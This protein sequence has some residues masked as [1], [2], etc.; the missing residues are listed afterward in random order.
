MRLR[1]I[2]LM[3]VMAVAALPG[4]AG[5]QEDAT[6]Y[7]VH[8]IPGA[9]VN[10]TAGG[11]AIIENFTFQSIEE[12]SLPAGTYPIGVSLTDGTEVYPEAD[13]TVEAGMTYVAVAYLGEDG[14]PASGLLVSEVNTSAIAAG[15]ARLTAFHTAAAPAVDILT[16]D[17]VLFDGVANGQSG[18][19]DVPADTYPVVIA[20]D[21]DN[22]V[23][24]FEGDVE[25]AEGANTLVFA[26][27]SLDDGNFG[28]VI[29]VVSGLGEMPEGVPSGEGPLGA[30]D[31]TLAVAALAAGAVAL[32][33]GRVLSRRGA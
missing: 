9:E 16:G 28:P 5:A 30:L 29:Q 21:A 15:E 33:F 18:D 32:G 22:S 11:D 24:A 17:T 7:V 3:A 12:L 23:V 26:I 14:N 4:I 27:G 25:L 6:V 13:V 10:V 1:I 19:I 20:A 8:G 31:A 2:A